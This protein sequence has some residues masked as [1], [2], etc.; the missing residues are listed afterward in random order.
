MED[1]FQFLEN[2]AEE[3]MNTAKSKGFYSSEEYNLDKDVAAMHAEVSE[4]WEAYSR[5]K[6]D[7]PCDKSDQM[8][9][10]IGMSLTCSE[11]EAADLIIKSLCIAKA[12]GI[13]IVKSVRA[14]NSFNKTR[15]FRHGKK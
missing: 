15:P 7:Q 12:L 11:E 3:F 2:L 13:D 10:K 6:L 8:L 5:G 4:L 1:H 14:K 9:E